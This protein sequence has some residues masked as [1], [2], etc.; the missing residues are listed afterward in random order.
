[1]S[2]WDQLLV[3]KLTLLLILKPYP[4]LL[5]RPAYPPSPKPREALEILIKELLELGVIRKVGHNEEAEITI[6]VIVAWHNGEYRMVGDFRAL[7]SYTV[8]HRYSIPKI[9]IAL[10]QIF[11]AVYIS[12]MDAL[13]GFN[14]NVVT[15]R[16]R[17]YFRIIV[18]CGVYEYLRITFG[19]KNAPSHFQRMMNEVFPEKLTE[20]WFIIYIY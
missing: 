2:N 9:Q 13:K 14:Q 3:M 20:G 10:T 5:R 8:P 6:Q 15:P 1:M 17:K 7:K 4:P 12:T 16:V 19:I 18:P 11:Q